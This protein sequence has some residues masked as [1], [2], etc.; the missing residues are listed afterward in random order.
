MIIDALF[1]NPINVNSCFKGSN[2][3]KTLMTLVAD[4]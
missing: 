3:Q 4:N 1:V 2:F